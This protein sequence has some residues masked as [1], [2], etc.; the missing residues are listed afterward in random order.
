[1]AEITS[2]LPAPPNASHPKVQNR[3]KCLPSFKK[4]TQ[5]AEFSSTLPAPPNGLFQGIELVG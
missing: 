5:M 4:K 3:L 2:T 1:M